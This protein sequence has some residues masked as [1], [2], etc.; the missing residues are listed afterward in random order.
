MLTSET[1]RSLAVK[2]LAEAETLLSAGLWDG[3]YY[4]AGYAAECALKAIVADQF[5][6]HAIPDRRQV[7]STYTHSLPKLVDLAGLKP[8][9]DTEIQNLRF[10][11]HWETLKEW[12]ENSRYQEWSE[13]EAKAMVDALA[14]QDDGILR[15]IRLHW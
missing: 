15:W 11:E 12:N 6:A 8:A 14:N 13:S 9:L 10:L 7:E 2:R 1:L 3:A 5:V 4:L